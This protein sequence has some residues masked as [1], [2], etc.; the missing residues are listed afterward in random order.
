MLRLRYRH[1]VRLRKVGRF[2]LI[3]LGACILAGIVVLVYADS[4]I[5][6][7]RDG[8]H[9]NTEPTQVQGETTAPPKDRPVILNPII[10]IQEG[11]VAPTNFAEVGGVYITTSM[12][13]DM[14][15]VMELLQA[16]EEPCGVYLEL[17]SDFGNFYYSSSF[18]HGNYADGVD[19]KAVD[20]LIEYLKDNGFYMV[21][22]I[23]AF[24]DRAYVLENDSLCI[25]EQGGY[26]WMDS[27]GC[28]WLDPSN[29]AVIS[30][31]MQMGRELTERGFREICFT[32]FQFPD[33][34]N[35]VYG[36]DKSREEVIREAATEISDHFTKSEIIVSFATDTTDFPVAGG[37]IFVSGVDG[38]QV[39]RY[40][41][42][43]GDSETC[44][45]L[46]F[47]ADSKDARFDNYALLRP[48][49]AES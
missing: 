29:D 25:R 34:K 4:L 7:D 5:T 49:M 15:K 23:P 22:A 44:R 35:L 37:R 6:Y 45:E 10:E 33:G 28:Y 39:E 16:M 32:G 13:Q 41:G 2:L 38:S 20:A 47:L 11:P 42:A 3:A 30:R 46:V 31:L 48:L 26:G 19:V 9:L 8:A 14:P 40:A 18:S 21:A 24:P 36:S 43:Y 27:R 12:L 17:K 1:K